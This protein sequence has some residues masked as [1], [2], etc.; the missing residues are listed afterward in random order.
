MHEVSDAFA[1]GDPA[2]A[3]DA[4]LVIMKREIQAYAGSATIYTASATAKAAFTAADFGAI[5]GPILG[6]A[7]QLALVVQKIYLFAR[8]WNEMKAAN[9]LLLEGRYDLT[10]FKTCPLVGCYLLANSDTFAVINMAVADYGKTGW[11]FEVEVMVKR[12]QPVFDKAREVIRESRYEFAGLQ[13]M[14]GTVVN[15]NAKTL[16][17]P[18]G[19]L[20]GLL[21]DITKRVNRLGA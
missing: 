15:R 14:K 4:V 1:P 20:D 2:A 3:F 7:E 18:T 9:A 21:D 6:A 11:K 12:A 17:L 13:G 5:S 16:G 19:K 10:L 8:D